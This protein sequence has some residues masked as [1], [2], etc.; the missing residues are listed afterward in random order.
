MLQSRTSARRKQRRGDARGERSIYAVSRTARMDAA[1]QEVILARSRQ[2]DRQEQPGTADV[3]RSHPAP[4]GATDRQPCLAALHD[5]PRRSPI[6]RGAGGSIGRRYDSTCRMVQIAGRAQLAVSC[7]QRN[8][9][10]ALS[11]TSSHSHLLRR[12]LHRDFR[13]GNHLRHAFAAAE[14]ARGLPLSPKC[15]TPILLRL[16]TRAALPQENRIQASG[17]QGTGGD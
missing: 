8:S 16:R 12:W 15:G 11:V 14:L 1:A 3:P 4:I 9:A 7:E 10:T 5:V 2:D 13:L 6:R 17:A